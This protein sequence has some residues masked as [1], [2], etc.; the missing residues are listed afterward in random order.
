M[1]KVYVWLASMGMP[2]LEELAAQLKFHP[3]P[4]AVGARKMIAWEIRNERHAIGLRN[5]TVTF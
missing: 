2:E 5:K 1:H 4:W 3:D